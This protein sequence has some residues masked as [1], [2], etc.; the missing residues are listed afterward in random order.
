LKDVPEDV[1]PS[2]WACL[3]LS[4][5]GRL[6]ELAA[7]A[8]MNAAKGLLKELSLIIEKCGSADP[9]VFSC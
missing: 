2:A 7:T 8:E 6:E 9:H 1:P 4:D 5:V 3:W